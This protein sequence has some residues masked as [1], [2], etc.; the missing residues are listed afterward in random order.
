M[1]FDPC[2]YRPNGPPPERPDPGAPTERHGR[3]ML[4]GLVIVGALLTG[5]LEFPYALAG[6]GR[7]ADVVGL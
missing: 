4:A 7:L 1:P 6:I 3:L 2:E 5:L